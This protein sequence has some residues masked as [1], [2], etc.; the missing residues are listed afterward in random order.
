MTVFN[1]R[2][3][4]R[5]IKWNFCDSLIAGAR[6]GSVQSVMSPTILY[7]V[8][9]VPMNQVIDKFRAPFSSTQE[10]VH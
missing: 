3:F 2:S 1:F 8:V 6:M 9:P 4:F 5:L 7:L 10:I